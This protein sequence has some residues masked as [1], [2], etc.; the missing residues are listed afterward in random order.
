MFAVLVFALPALSALLI[1]RFLDRRREPWWL[2]SLTFVFGAIL[3]A[4]AIWIETKAHDVTGLDIRSQRS[5][6]NLAGALL[7]I[8]AVVAPLNELAK[9]IAVWPAYRSRHFDEPLDGI[10]Y[11]ATASLGFAAGA[12]FY[13]WHGEPISK[14]LVAR[15]LLS[16]PAH[17]FFASTWGY[18]L[19]RTKRTK[20]PGALFGTAWTVSTLLHAFYIHLVLGRGAGA[21]L[22]TA[23]L[24][25]V[26]GLVSFVAIR[27]L[28]K[29]GDAIEQKGEGRAS[30]LLERPSLAQVLLA[31]SSLRSV[32]SMIQVRREGLVVRWVLFGAIVIVGAMVTGLVAAIAFGHWAR[33]DFAAVDEQNVATTGPVALLGAGMLAAFPASGYLIAKASGLPTLLE[34]ALASALA[35]GL[36]LLFFGFTAPVA[37]IFALAFSPVAWGLTCVG[38]WI[39]RTR[40]ATE[41]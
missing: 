34:P 20:R 18:A 8:A 28:V 40:V 26:M 37:L 41:A 13:R 22:A 30:M 1:A 21:L 2:V 7:F 17:V 16:L 33:V 4:G 31:P 35:I 14:L 3:A 12:S 32:Q 29:R 23:P 9:V 24:L 11:A 19:G 15:L 5:G 6:G 25:L 27:D 38:A 36:V 39:G 10:I